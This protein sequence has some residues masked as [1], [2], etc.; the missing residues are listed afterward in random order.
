MC[1]RAHAELAIAV[2]HVRADR[3]RRDAEPLGDLVVG[4]AVREKQKHVAFARGKHGA[5]MSSARRAHHPRIMGAASANL[6]LEPN[7]A[8]RHLRGGRF[9]VFLRLLL[10]ARSLESLPDVCVV[11]RAVAKVAIEDALHGHCSA[12]SSRSSTARITAAA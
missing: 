6:T 10:A 8:H 12:M 11:A 3:V 9:L 1:G 5:I 2:L 7:D 4:A